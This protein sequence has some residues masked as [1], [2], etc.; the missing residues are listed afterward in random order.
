[1]PNRFIRRTLSACVVLALAISAS[2]A[3]AE[4]SCADTGSPCPADDCALSHQGIGRRLCLADEQY[5]SPFSIGVDAIWLTHSGSAF[6]SEILDPNSN[7]TVIAQDLEHGLPVAPRLRLG[8]LLFED[9]RSEV[10][11]FGTSD[12]GSTARVQNV[13]PLP[14]LS[15]DIAYDAELH[16]F[17]F[18]FF[19]GQSEVDS[20]WMIGLRY[21]SYRDSFEEAYQLET[22]FGPMIEEVA[23]GDAKNEA[24]GP[25]VGG[26]IDF[27]GGSTFLHL[28]SKLGFMN[29]RIRQRGPGYQ[30]ALV[31]DG[32]PET[33]F[34]SKTDEFAWLAE[35]EL[36]LNHYVTDHV[37]FRV[38]YQ[39]L[40]LDNVA[41]SATQN[42]R[43]ADAA[44]ISFHGVVLGMQWIR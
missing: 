23:R 22:G 29:N 8:V 36:T 20:H 7:A 37:S 41:Q 24:F 6:R 2:V 9:F 11:Y 1:M 27:G 3:I 12:W 10:S 25:Q 19:S 43:Q 17:E 34:Q 15:A 32:T 44:Q 18:N 28:G 14:D 4:V 31:I 42:G 33:S 21:L 35:L 39:G 16:N 26:G 30:N 38:G 40:F 5:R 13:A